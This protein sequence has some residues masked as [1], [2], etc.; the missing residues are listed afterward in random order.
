MLAAIF[1]LHN[2]ASVKA[3]VASADG[4]VISEDLMKDID[5]PLHGL[6]KGRHLSKRQPVRAK[7]TEASRAKAEKSPVGFGWAM[8][9]TRRM[10]VKS[11]DGFWYAVVFVEL[12][13]QFVKLYFL[14]EKTADTFVAAVEI[15]GKLNVA[16]LSSKPLVGAAFRLMRAMALGLGE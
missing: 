6:L 7:T 10:G 11:V 9:V 14:K 12:R 13:I 5:L 2:R 3:M 15:L 1:N 16:D 8:D 4:V